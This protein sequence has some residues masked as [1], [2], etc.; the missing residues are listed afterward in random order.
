M[1]MF[2]PAENMFVSLLELE[3]LPNNEK[4]VLQK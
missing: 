2:M 3:F 4:C 1:A